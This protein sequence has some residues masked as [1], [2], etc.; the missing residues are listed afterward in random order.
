MSKKENHQGGRRE[1]AVKEV[2]EFSIK[3]DELLHQRIAEKAY[4]LY[5]CRDCCHGHDVEDWLEAERLVSTEFEPPAQKKKE[6]A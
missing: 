1:I 5:E 3:Q 2:T 6:S 4:Q